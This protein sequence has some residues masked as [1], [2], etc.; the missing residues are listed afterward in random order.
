MFNKKRKEIHVVYHG[1]AE[2]RARF[3]W[4][5]LIALLIGVGVLCLLSYLH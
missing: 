1:V 3:Q 4:F 2:R 5:L